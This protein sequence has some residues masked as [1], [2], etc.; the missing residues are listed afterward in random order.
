V[1]LR[2]AY[3]TVTNIFALLRLLPVNG[4]EKNAEILALRHQVLVLH[5]QLGPARARFARLTGLY[6]QPCWAGSRGRQPSECTS[7]C[8]RTPCSA[9]TATFSRGGTPAVPDPGKAHGTTGP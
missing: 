1:L 9:G 3:L 6:W 4:K 2:L 8:A 5:R 7:W